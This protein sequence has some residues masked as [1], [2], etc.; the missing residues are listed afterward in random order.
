MERIPTSVNLIDLKYLL[1]MVAGKIDG[2][3]DIEKMA[4]GSQNKGLVLRLKLGSYH[5][6]GDEQV[7]IYRIKM[8]PGEAITI[9]TMKRLYFER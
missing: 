1:P 5:P 3:Y 2:Y 4:F 7:A 8:Q 6:L 9:S